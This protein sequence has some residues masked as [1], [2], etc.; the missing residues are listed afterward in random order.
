MKKVFCSICVLFVLIMCSCNDNTNVWKD[1]HK[2]YGDGTYQIFNHK[3]NGIDIKGIS[4]SKCHQCIIDEIRSI[5]E[6]DE[7]VYVY[8]KFTGHDV[9]TVIDTNNNKAKYFVICEPG[10][11]LGMTNINELIKSGT[12]EFLSSY[13]YFNEKEK[14]IFNDIKESK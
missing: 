12:F 2:V 5:K 9:Y 1:T 3:K 6:I 14:E 4:N 10:D 13:D 7:F 8:G 11:V